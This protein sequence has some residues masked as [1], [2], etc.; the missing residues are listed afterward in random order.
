[1]AS[2]F[3]ENLRRTSHFHYRNYPKM[4]HRLA[5]HMVPI[6]ERPHYKARV[7]SGIEWVGDLFFYLLD[8]VFVSYFYQ[9]FSPVFKRDMRWLTPQEKELA[10][11]FYK[12]NFNPYYVHMHPRM[13]LWIR[14]KAYAYVSLHTI[15]Y[16]TEISRS[17]L[18]HEMAHSWQY[19]RYG[20][21]YV[22]RA[23]LNQREE[24]CYDY[25]GLQGLYDSMVSGKSLDEFGFEQQAQ[26]LQDAYDYGIGSRIESVSL[27]DGVFRYY[28]DQIDS[29]KMV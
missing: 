13:P 10:L 15:N 21:V 2:F 14:R 28:H 9:I 19:Q 7:D 6:G 22:F 25:G 11:S 8:V 23:L 18:V 20:S 24:N 16:R 17:V 29:S 4:L 5:Y 26:I 1:M 27:V 3:I 12:G